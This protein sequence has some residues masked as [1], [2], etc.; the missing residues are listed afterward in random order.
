M[1]AVLMNI[2]S[3]PGLSSAALVGTVLE[4]PKPFCA[5]YKLKLP[6]ALPGELFLHM[7]GR[8]FVQKPCYPLLNYSVVFKAVD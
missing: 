5:V 6:R 8:V 3:N 1:E 2:S 4:Y 7:R